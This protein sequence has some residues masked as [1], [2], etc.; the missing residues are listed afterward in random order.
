MKNKTP[1]KLG[2]PYKAGS[3][4]DKYI[5]FYVSLGEL[6]SFEHLEKNVLA[7]YAL[8]N[9]HYNRSD[10]FRLICKY[11]DD[12]RLLNILLENPSEDIKKVD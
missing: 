2:P 1:P 10:H 5:K 7:Y 3:P 6:I 9:F 8:H 12:V 11:F 4:R